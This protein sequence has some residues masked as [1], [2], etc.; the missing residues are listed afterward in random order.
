MYFRS[1]RKK[2][3]KPIAICF[4]GSMLFQL[5]SP[6]VSM[7]IT[8]HDTMPEYTS[9][10][11][12]GTSN[13]V[14]LFDGSFT[15]NIPLMNVPNGYP[16]NLS[17][18][19]GDVNSEA[20]ASW[21]GLGW[22]INPG[23]INRVKRG[24]P[25]E[26]NGDS[27]TYWNR[28]PANWTIGLGIGVRAEFFSNE[29]DGTQGLLGANLGATVNFNNYK[30]VATSANIGGHIAG[31][32]N[33]NL[34]FSQ[35]QIGFDATIDPAKIFHKLIPS[36]GPKTKRT[37][38]WE[39][40][41][42]EAE[43]WDSLLG[44]LRLESTTTKSSRT[45]FS[46]AIPLGNVRYPSVPNPYTGFMASFEFSLG[47]NLL[48]V[49]ID[50]EGYINGTFA[51]QVMDEKQDKPVYGYLHNHDAIGDKKGV[52]DYFSE[53]D[54]P[55]SKREKY[56]GYPVPSYDVFSQSGESTGGNFRPWR[57][58]YGHYRPERSTSLDFG[59]QVEIDVNVPVSIFPFY[60]NTV[61]T[62]GW[63]VGGS[64]HSTTQ[65]GWK[66]GEFKDNQAHAFKFREQDDETFFFRH[67]GDK[68]GYIDHSEN[69]IKFPYKAALNGFL[70]SA[71]ADLSNWGGGSPILHGREQKQRS[72]YIAYNTN[73]ELKK[74]NWND[75][76]RYKAYQQR[77][78]VKNAA[79]GVELFDDSDY[80][81]GGDENIGEFTT[82][83][84]AGTR[85]VYGLPVYARNE[86]QLSYSLVKGGTLQHDA[87]YL[88]TTGGGLLADV[89]K[90]SFDADAKR[91]LGFESMS[92]YATTHLLTEVSS[93]NYVDRMM[94]GP[95][96]DDFGTYSR[97]NYER[98]AGG[99]SNSEWYTHRSPY[100]G[101]NYD[102][103]SVSEEKDDMG[104]L[105]YVEKEI[106]N[107]ESVVSKTHVAIF[108]MSD[109][110]DA[111]SA[112]LEAG[113]SSAEEIAQ[114]DAGYQPVAAK[115]LK[116][117]DRIDLYA[118]EDVTPIMDAGES[119]EFYEPNASAKP[120]QTVHFQYDYTLC[121]GLPNN[122]NTTTPGV[123]P[124]L[125]GK[126][127]L[128]KVWM[129]YNGQLTSKVSPY[130]FNYE[131]PTAVN[132]PAPYNATGDPTE[133][134]AYG[135]R[136]DASLSNGFPNGQNPEN[137]YYNALATD[138]WGCYRDYYTMHDNVPSPHSIGA[139]AQFWPF[140]HQNPNPGTY[141]PAA[142]CLKEI[143]LPS[144][145]HI[146]VQYEQNE[147][148]FVQNKN[149]Y[150]M[151]PLRGGA[152]FT[153]PGEGDVDGKRYYL[154]LEKIGIPYPGLADEREA[155]AK[156]LFRP[157]RLPNTN[158]S[159]TTTDRERIFFRFLY[160]LV[161]IN[162][163][164]T[165][166]NSEFLEGY[167]RVYGFGFDNTGVFFTFKGDPGG[168]GTFFPISYP[169]ESSRWEVPQKVCTQFIASSKRGLLGGNNNTALGDDVD[170]NSN[171]EQVANTF[172]NFLSS[173]IEE[174]QCLQIAP[175]MSYVRVQLP[176]SKSKLGAGCRVKRLLLY[177]QGFG[178]NDTGYD[179]EI[180]SL[181]GT[182]FEYVTT[183]N[184]VE[185]SSGVAANEPTSGRRENSL[186]Y[187]L[188][189]E[190]QK[191]INAILF[192]QDMYSQEGPLGESF[193][194]GPSVGY[195]KV[196][197]SPIHKGTTSTGYSVHEYHTVRDFPMEAYNTT[198]DQ[199]NRVPIGLGH[200]ETTSTST[201]NLDP[202][203]DEAL[204]DI[205]EG[206]VSVSYSRNAPYL[207]QGYSF[208]SH[209]MHGR[210]KRSGQYAQGASTAHAWEEIEYYNP[211]DA[212]QFL[213]ENK[214]LEQGYAYMLGG[215]TEM[216]SRARKV[217]DLAVSGYYEQDVST[218]GF[219][220]TASAPIIV[221][222]IPIYASIKTKVG[223]NVSENILNEHVTSK[224]TTY[225]AIVK[226]VT[227]HGDRITNV[228]EIT[229]FDILTGEPAIT[230]SYDDF[231]GAYHNIAFSGAYDHKNLRSRA[232]NERFTLDDF[233]LYEGVSGAAN[234]NDYLVYSGTD[235]A[236]LARFIEGD[237]IE[238]RVYPSEVVHGL[239]HI[240][241]VDLPTSRI[242]LQA[243]G[244]NTVATAYQVLSSIKVLK[245]GYTNQLKAIQGSV[246]IFKTAAD[247]ELT[248]LQSPFN[249]TQALNTLN[250][251]ASNA[252]NV[253][254]PPNTGNICATLVG[255]WCVDG[256]TYTDP[257][258][259]IGYVPNALNNHNLDVGYHLYFGEDGKDFKLG[260]CMTLL[261]ET[262]ALMDLY[263]SAPL[264]GSFTFDYT[265]H[266]FSFSTFDNCS[267]IVCLTPC[268]VSGVTTLNDVVAAAAVSFSDYWP[269]DASLY[270][271]IGT[272]LAN[273]YETG[274]K[275]TW[276]TE[277]TFVYRE[278]INVD[279]DPTTNPNLADKLY[280]FE[281][282]VFTMEMFDW[283]N[284]AKYDPS[285]LDY[286]PTKLWLFT[287]MVNKYSP[288]GLPI[289]DRN[290]LGIRSTSKLGDR[291]TVPTLVAQN[292]HDHT[293]AFEAFEKQYDFGGTL[294][295]EDG[296]VYNSTAGHWTQKIAHSGTSS[297]ELYAD[298]WFPVT[299]K[300][301]L[302]SNVIRDGGLLTRIWVN[303]PEDTELEDELNIRYGGT[304]TSTMKLVA[305]AGDWALY[306]DYLEVTSANVSSFLGTVGSEYVTVE[307]MTGEDN[308]YIDDA[309]TQPMESEMVCYVY[310]SSQRLIAM[311]DDQHFALF[312]QY[313]AEGQL[314]RQKIETYNGVKTV[315]EG[316][317]NS[318]GVS[319]PTLKQN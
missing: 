295:F 21:V 91:K 253:I 263:P 32:L 204:G 159:G 23:T 222:V 155:L 209:S 94:D 236:G 182:E 173:F 251:L 202:G 165:S 40:S 231:G 317:Y 239:F 316:Q 310:D 282:G 22:N 248:E 118:L 12:V 35:G 11:P 111:Q 133:I 261:D 203:M 216:L 223:I 299:N 96:P 176:L 232:N 30:G 48:P 240:D 60:V 158:S 313:N 259:C 288:N 180:L 235:C 199:V 19:S 71:K 156:E 191:K 77:I 34:G 298:Q 303:A 104:S 134:T 213:N 163:T 83:N 267:S 304:A 86:K 47:P 4:A 311:L 272:F 89:K 92:P 26:W 31:V 306:E 9:F 109:R 20:M 150:A 160:G 194:P 167:A 314:V 233:K 208:V 5:L 234:E 242:Y 27:V 287:G 124:D 87:T 278:N 84:N 210:E 50:P 68:G 25:D 115:S 120:I 224:I 139:L 52:M 49:P 185:I 212:I 309:R 102:L 46:M 43:D 117:L 114:H 250:T 93:P 189:R 262:P 61:A 297:I 74:T 2:A 243:S 258:L 38:D 95:T 296:L 142:W 260:P 101:L 215:E 269:Y 289:E 315:S 81:R 238:L 174:A 196:T 113:S 187:P 98:V 192:G 179:E 183:E 112:H 103:G 281:E 256:T 15:Y 292:A 318:Q 37:Y 264:A 218:G 44:N 51:M 70:I 64:F 67:L 144:G 122:K 277:G 276:R 252:H 76:K 99:P 214:Q 219:I 195:S 140:V 123:D 271:S 275:G 143:E 73:D 200:S 154:D 279:T 273:E 125:T 39:E 284:P 220:W 294:H 36:K 227:S 257:Q 246:S 145:G 80:T 293:V 166:A 268:P 78:Y 221:G 181:Y 10:E 59:I 58:E 130:V 207:S 153:E 285:H 138:R 108:T 319:R 198:I 41:D 307:I 147:Y 301:K 148:Q 54:K 266:T 126:L 119:S 161:G 131:Y 247:V 79:G 66:D 57:S 291:G 151:V 308:V 170:D 172:L 8:G 65:K 129:E 226:R 168:N 245:S 62:N 188:D 300:V 254:I 69:P 211:R 157:M 286:D 17:Y 302:E 7:A 1:I 106:Y 14:N 28:M 206:T 175:E 16:I 280:N 72:S 33:L 225:P 290:I 241:E 164:Y 228:S 265:S 312:Y 244:L 197:V 177:D 274:V 13:M 230:K 88:Q 135:Q 63:T 53:L 249:P 42:E 305:S 193:L 116:Q 6:T 110:A 132:L 29:S 184:G 149:A 229:A 152:G 105:H 18:H 141:D 128:R 3:L 201:D 171:L 55:Y 283:A 162:P 75:D 90:P 56:I 178:K 107:L 169:T 137:P 82:H 45:G 97:F 136:F 24:Q 205:V 190:D 121:R 255:D 237:F 100:F 270:S 217:A 85:Y 146:L 186:V 127:T